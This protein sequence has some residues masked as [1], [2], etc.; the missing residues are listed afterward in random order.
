MHC[1]K[2][3]HEKDLHAVTSSICDC[4]RRWLLTS[5]SEMHRTECFHTSNSQTPSDR[6][7]MR[8]PKGRAPCSPCPH[9]R[10][11]H[12]RI[13]PEPHLEFAWEG[14]PVKD[15]RILQQKTLI[16]GCA[17]DRNSAAACNRKSGSWLSRL[18]TSYQHSVPAAQISRVRKDDDVGLMPRF[19][20]SSSSHSVQT[21]PIPTPS[22]QSYACA[23]VA[24]AGHP[25]VKIGR[26]ASRS[27]HI[28]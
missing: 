14:G 17:E 2:R 21:M 22:I 20:E 13:Y 1:G 4:C 25:R 16:D 12:C 10:R 26:N 19:A 3:I 7:P 27:A 15:S 5:A 9:D 28:S 11:S 24:D 23:N 18:E 8:S 6:L